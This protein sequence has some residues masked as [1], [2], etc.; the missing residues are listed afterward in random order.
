ML[1]LF[2][3]SVIHRHVS[4]CFH[5]WIRPFYSNSH[6]SEIVRRLHPV[7]DRSALFEATEDS[8][9]YEILQNI[10]STLGAELTTTGWWHQETAKKFSFGFR[11]SFQSSIFSAGS[12]RWPDVS[13]ESGHLVEFSFFCFSG[14]F[15][16]ID[17]RR[18]FCFPKK[19]RRKRHQRD[20]NHITQNTLTTPDSLDVRETSSEVRNELVHSHGKMI[21]QIVQH[22]ILRCF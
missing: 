6:R 21:A 12:S 19:N 7:E 10:I 9:L 2:L 5:R 17:N 15:W 20:T 1:R 8:F 16:T 4:R 18:N 14:I 13:A 3:N 22:E 11:K